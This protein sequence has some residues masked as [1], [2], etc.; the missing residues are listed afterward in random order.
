MYIFILW[1]LSEVGKSTGGFEQCPQS[2]I[3]SNF[4]R[5]FPNYEFSIFS[6]VRDCFEIVFTSSFFSTTIKMLILLLNFTEDNFINNIIFLYRH[7]S[8]ASSYV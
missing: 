8:A 2:G 3:H 7:I 5:I 6:P 1:K 4:L